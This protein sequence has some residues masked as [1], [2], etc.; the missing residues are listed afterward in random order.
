MYSLQ[1]RLTVL[2]SILMRCTRVRVPAILR[3]SAA[4][5]RWAPA[6]LATP[7]SRA[8]LAVRKGIPDLRSPEA[9]YCLRARRLASIVVLLE[10]L[11]PSAIRDDASSSMS[12]RKVA[13]TIFNLACA[14]D[15]LMSSTNCLRRQ[16]S[17]YRQDL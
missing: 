17:L 3:L 10:I 16:L 9:T 11:Q 5:D 1:A 15:S 2:D 6:V 4:V 7:R 8:H 13:A 14:Y 12:L